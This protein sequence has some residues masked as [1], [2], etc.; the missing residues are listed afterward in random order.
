MSSTGGSRS[1]F[2][3]S[4][5]EA[6]LP[7]PL[8]GPVSWQTSSLETD[9][10]GVVRDALKQAS[11]QLTEQDEELAKQAG[12]I[13]QFEQRLQ[14][15]NDELNQFAYVAS[16]DLQEPLRK[17]VGFCQAL[18]EDYNDSLDETARGY[19]RYAVEGALRMKCLVADLLSY[20]RL[21]TQGS[22]LQP[23]DAGIACGE[24][25]RNLGS[26][27]EKAGAT[28]IQGN[29][30]V[31]SADRAQLVRLFQ[32]LISNAIKYRREEEPR[33]EVAADERHDEWL[34]NVRDNGLGI[35]PQYYERIFV[36]FQRLHARDEYSGTGIG[37]AVCKR[38]VQRMGGRIWVESTPGAGS[39]FYFSVPKSNH[40]LTL[41]PPAVVNSLAPLTSN[42]EFTSS[43]PFGR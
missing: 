23:T 2:A 26:A 16:H 20:S 17:V 29:L 41:S 24:A 36:V 4:S 11:R 15:M 39:T 31:I 43:N 33:V 1:S 5:F 12:A 30:P 9:V 6:S 13:S 25:I 22:P 10:A 38:I 3:E 40:T 32:D 37:L 21:Q 34:F 42:D 35:D 8:T 27:I 19:I 7:Q 18:Q 28:I 14:R